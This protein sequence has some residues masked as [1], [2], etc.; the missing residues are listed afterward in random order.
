M[1]SVQEITARTNARKAAK[2]AGTVDR[3]A[4]DKLAAQTGGKAQ[5]D[6]GRVEYQ[7]KG[8]GYK[9]T[10]Y[11]RPGET[12][13]MEAKSSRPG[14]KGEVNAPVGPDQMEPE[15]DTSQPSPENVQAQPFTG[16]TPMQSYEQATQ[17][18]S[19]GGLS[20]DTL[21]QARSIVDNK[22]QKAHQQL[23]SSGTPPPADGGAA[24]AQVYS[25]TP[26]EADR[27]AV[28][29]VFSEDPVINTIMQGAFE[30]LQPDQRKTS[31]MDDYKKLYRSSGLD[32]L[33]EEIIDAETILDGSED[34]IRNEI[35]MAGGMATES[36][37]Q[38]MTL[39]RNKG[40]LK[41][42]NQLFSMRES[43]QKQ[44]DTMLNI[45]VQDRQMAQQEAQNRLNTMF[46]LANFRQQAINA[47]Q[48]TARFNLQTLGADGMYNSLQG[49][50]VELA[51]YE[52][53]MGLPAGGL[54]TA[55]A[56]A[57]TTRA[58]EQYLQNL[59]IRKAEQDV[60]IGVPAE[61]P[62][63]PYQTERS[64]RILDEATDLF[65][66]VSGETAGFG[67]LM[68]LI[69]ESKARDFA[70]DLESLKANVFSAELQAMRADSKTGGA[71]GSASEKE[72]ENLK[73]ALGGLDQGQSPANLKKNFVKAMS[74]V[75]R[76]HQ[77]K[78]DQMYTGV[79]V[80]D[81]PESETYGQLIQIID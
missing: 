43:A 58:N 21:A 34:D 11:A 40:L 37:V 28:E 50:P 23:T 20:G 2:K 14:G 46:Q 10:R 51:R 42:Y 66:R 16:E 30:F 39:A 78:G 6:K 9:A 81:D 65:S 60:G 52:R 54:A 41:R 67:S 4:L 32:E 18:L 70:A 17:A 26:Y 27:S 22:Y 45:T 13:N 44:L 68:S 36:Q 3:G 57:A 73:S 62:F 75:V 19:A 77:A 74:A 56:Q 31:L 15:V 61:S 53:M 35:K 49:N 55:A 25:A 47:Y 59:Q 5:Y 33:N 63:S 38:A 71:I 7:V 79:V 64:I 1:A 80:D 48:E 76:Y 72:G 69:P 8:N 29:A 12:P 24:M